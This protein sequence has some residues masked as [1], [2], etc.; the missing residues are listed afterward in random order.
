MYIAM[1]HYVR[2]LRDSRYPG[3]KGLELELFR[4]QIDFF[5]RHFTFADPALLPEYLSGAAQI[6]EDSVMLTFDDGYMDHYTNVYPILMEYKIKGLFSMP[7]KMIRENCVLDVNKIHF[8]LALTPIKQLLDR[9]YERLDHYRGLEY[10]IEDNAS[11]FQR[12]GV[13]NRF[14]SA[15]VIFVKRLLQVELPEELRNR[16]VQDLFQQV[17]P[18][19]ESAFSKELYMS[20]D[21]V[22][23]MKK[24]GM[25]FAYHGYD[26]YWMNRLSETEL[27]RDIE[28]ALEVFD[29]IMD[30]Q[31]WLCCYPYGSVSDSVVACVQK[32]G[33]AAGLS[34]VVGKVDF[35]SAEPY[36]LPRMDTNDFPPK[37]ERY[38]GI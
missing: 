22:K 28:N 25:T 13:A 33:A 11:L 4:R 5:S 8:I 12:L 23:L 34:T 32:M 37:S 6:P 21:H 3:I 15:E 17:L 24:S 26:H 16:I 29:G 30:P 1:Y 10:Q 36:K 20:L 31:R 19:S 2:D 7:G 38:K 18:V 27:V 9:V 14:D 35:P